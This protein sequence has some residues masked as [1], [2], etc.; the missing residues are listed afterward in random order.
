MASSP[1]QSLAVVMGD[2][3]QS[4]RSPAPERLHA[5]FNDV[6][7]MLNMR[8][9]ER[10]VS[11]LTITLGDEFQGLVKSLADA[12]PIVRDMR[13]HL[14]AKAIDCRFVIGSVEI[15]TEINPDK[16]WNMMGPGLSRARE[17]LNEK[18]TGSLYRFS[19][20]DDP[21]AETLLEAVGAGLT[22]IERG[23]TDRQR[24]DISALI[25]G[26]SAAELAKH[27]NVSVHSIYK[28]RSSGN[29]DA[30]TMQWHAIGE[31]LAALDRRQERS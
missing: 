29:F 26:L 24:E 2:L 16:A 14:M 3:V 21:V 23:W 6:V 15:R 18:R 30:Y 5:Q 9:R 7:D 20:L 17:R 8:Y 19:I 31:A 10:L 28:V 11:P 1:I 27:R 13:L 12:A 25:K 22:A 4:E